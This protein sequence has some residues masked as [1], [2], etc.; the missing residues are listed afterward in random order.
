M[1]TPKGLAGRMS[2]LR[3][4]CY[5]ISKV[6]CWAVLR[7]GCGLSVHGREHVPRQGPFILAS[8]HVS[9]LDPV[10]IGVACPRSLRF[11]AREN[12]FHYALLGRYLR[13]VGVIPIQRGEVDLASIR[14]AVSC[15]RRGEV[16][17]IF[18]EGGR[19]FSGK[20]GVAR[21]G[22]GLLAVMAKVPIVPILVTGTF[23]ALPP[24]EKR[25]HRAKIQVAFGPQIPYTLGLAIFKPARNHHEQLA[26]AVTRQWHRLEAQ[27]AGRS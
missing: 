25:L 5:L 3:S 1:S 11:M 8:N 10:V 7:L 19:Q 24:G 22:V 20:L 16:V 9:Y 2:G 15:L 12:L 23:Q 17:A 13:A 26:S 6:V 18:P 4:L 14:E 27:W 21:R